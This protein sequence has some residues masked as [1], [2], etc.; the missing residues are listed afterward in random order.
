M[1]GRISNE[2]LEA[3]EEMA[4]K[5]DNIVDRRISFPGVSI[6]HLKEEGS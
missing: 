5:D 6:V 3:L 4:N 2:N 1:S